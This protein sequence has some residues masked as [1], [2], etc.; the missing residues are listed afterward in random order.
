MADSH[1]LQSKMR[2][3]LSLQG[4]IVEIDACVRQV[5]KSMQRVEGR[6]TAAMRPGS[7]GASSIGL[8]D[9]EVDKDSVRKRYGVGIT[10]RAAPPTGEVNGNPA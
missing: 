9:V 1:L 6:Q 5:L 2:S 7:S 3:V 4:E 8:S 10:R